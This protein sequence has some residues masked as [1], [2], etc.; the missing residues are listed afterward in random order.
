M[1]WGMERLKNKKGE[2]YIFTCVLV[3]FI[4]T[5]LSVILLYMSLLGKIEF[6]KND[7]E[8]KLDGFISDYAT[9]MFDAIKQGDTYAS[10]ID[11]DSL[12]D[13]AYKALGFENDC[14]SEFVY[15][16]GECAMSRPTVTV[17]SGNGFG[18]K[19]DYVASFA[20]NWNGKA[21]ADV[22]IPITVTSYYKPK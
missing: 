3:L 21:Y 22:E 18:V 16:G 2:A 6:Q 17:L 19:V 11:W 10:S 1:R 7:V 4:A 20:V 9:E 5:L 14:T 13:G 15:Q 12:E 8:S